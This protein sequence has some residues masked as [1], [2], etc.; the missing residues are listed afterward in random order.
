MAVTRGGDEGASIL[1]RRA[2]PAR[3]GASGDQLLLS[4]SANDAAGGRTRG[5]LRSRRHGRRA[6]AEDVDDDDDG[7]ALERHENAR[8]GE[9]ELS[10]RDLEVSSQYLN[11]EME[12]S[13]SV[14]GFTRLSPTRL[15]L[16]SLDRR[17]IV[18]ASLMA[19]CAPRRRVASRPCGATPS[20]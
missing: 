13:C 10:Q 20:F 3:S 5:E 11:V 9:R 18:A 16:G 4:L 17:S 6:A 14:C 12:I 2:V 8:P 19:R 7:A 15:Q 1:T